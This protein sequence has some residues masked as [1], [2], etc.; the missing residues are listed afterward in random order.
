MLASWL[1]C[2]YNQSL[3]SHLINDVDG[4]FELLPHKHRNEMVEEYVE[5]LITIA[6]WNHNGDWNLRE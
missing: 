5:M 3:V 6:E 2:P 1:V 4:E